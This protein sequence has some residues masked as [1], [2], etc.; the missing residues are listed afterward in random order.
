MIIQ[1]FEKFYT[2]LKNSAIAEIKNGIAFNGDLVCPDFM[3]VCCE[4][5]QAIV[6][7]RKLDECCKE[8][9][10]DDDV[11]KAFKMTGRKVQTILLFMAEYQGG[12]EEE[13]RRYSVALKMA[14]VL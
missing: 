8:L 1:S 7:Q 12:V 2:N 3:E 4:E 6:I 10:Q 5:S 14:P 13:M 9:S 11:Y